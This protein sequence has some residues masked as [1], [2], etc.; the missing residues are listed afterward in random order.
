MSTRG[1]SFGHLAIFD[2]TAH[3]TAQ[4]IKKTPGLGNLSFRHQFNGSIGKIFDVTG[5]GE[6]LRHTLRGP[7]KA[8][9]LNPS[10]KENPQKKRILAGHEYFFS[11]AGIAIGKPFFELPE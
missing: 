10:R 4:G 9:T 11:L 5:Y 7:P 6:T 8:N 1:R 2:V 3:S